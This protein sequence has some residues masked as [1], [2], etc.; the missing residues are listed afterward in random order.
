MAYTYKELKSKT[1]AQLREIAATLSTEAVKGYTQLHKDQ[2]LMALCAALGIDMHE[3]HEVQGL[4]KASLKLRIRALKQE[5]EKALAAHD[6]KQL[7]AIR[8]RIK[9]YKKQ[10]R[11]AMV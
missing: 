11:K 7:Q 10:I 5:R 1:V 6:S 3:H 2:L 4:D 9:D 8:R